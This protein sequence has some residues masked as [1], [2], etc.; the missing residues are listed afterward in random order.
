MTC[1]PFGAPVPDTQV[2]KCGDDM[3]TVSTL[4]VLVLLH[5]ILYGFAAYFSVFVSSNVMSFGAISMSSEGL[6]L[7][8][9]HIFMTWWRASRPC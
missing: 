9:I 5:R 4:S 1:S 8:N 3:S 6:Q 2:L 7:E